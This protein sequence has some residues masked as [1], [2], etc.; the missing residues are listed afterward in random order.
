MSFLFHSHNCFG[1][2]NENIY[3]F[4]FSTSEDIHEGI[5]LIRGESCIFFPER[6]E[7]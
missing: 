3:L 1:K 5:T 4:K 2:Y 6:N 7:T